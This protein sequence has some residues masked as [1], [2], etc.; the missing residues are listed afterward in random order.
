MCSLTH[1]IYS[2]KAWCK[3][4][5]RGG[6]TLIQ[7]RQKRAGTEGTRTT[8]KNKTGTT[9]S[10]QTRRQAGGFSVSCISNHPNWLSYFSE[11]W[12]NHRDDSIGDVPVCHPW[13]LEDWP[14][15]HRLKDAGWHNLSTWYECWPH[16]RANMTMRDDEGIPQVFG[17][18]L[19][20]G[21]F[22]IFPYFSFWRYHCEIRSIL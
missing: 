12:L 4:K 15:W 19:R 8:A 18:E 9:P 11:G 10:N 20:E 17:V 14:W 16:Q 21:L 7:T 5:T 3:T 1:A 2:P 13:S 22:F 6:V